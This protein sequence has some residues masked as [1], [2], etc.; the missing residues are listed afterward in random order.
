VQVASNEPQDMVDASAGLTILLL[1]A[2]RG[3]SQIYTFIIPTTADA[4][5]SSPSFIRTEWSSKVDDNK[6]TLLIHLTAALG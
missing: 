5:Q 4:G 3:D 1:C 2:R 6:Q